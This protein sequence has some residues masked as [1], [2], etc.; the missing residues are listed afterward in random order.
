MVINFLLLIFVALLIV[1][2][3][4]IYEG[5]LDATSAKEKSE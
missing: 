5:Q 3:P 2:L 1:A 4:A